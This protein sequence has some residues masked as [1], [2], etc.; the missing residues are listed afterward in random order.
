MVIRNLIGRAQECVESGYELRR[1]I[2]QR[3]VRKI[4]G[5]SEILCQSVA[6]QRIF[7]LGAFA[8]FVADELSII[9]QEVVVKIE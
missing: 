8:R 5:F 3:N 2:P 4:V 1:N 7:I 9:V 6:Y